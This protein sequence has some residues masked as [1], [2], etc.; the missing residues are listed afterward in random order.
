MIIW[1]ASYPKSGNT[2]V[3]SLL[4]S[5]IF[6]KDGSFS[7]E[8]LKNIKQFPDNSLFKKIG[9]DINNEE[10]MYKNYINS[11]KIFHNKKSIR[12]L[13]THSAFVNKDGFKFTDAKHTLGVI[14][15][16]RDPRNIVSSFSHHFQKN[17]K[18][19]LENLLTPQY[20]GKE[21]VSHCTTW[22]GSWKYHYNSWK[23]FQKYNRYLIVKYEDL[24]LSTE[25]TFINILKFI[26]R[27]NNVKFTINSKKLTKTL[28]TTSFNKMQK[29][30]KEENF[31]EAKINSKTG[32]K[33]KFFNL[34]IKNDWKKFLDLETKKKLEKELE[35]EM[36][37][38]NY[39][40]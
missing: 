7:F 40:D 19:S 17:I 6:S 34:G 10:E 26:A 24:V 32:E 23:T 9:V 27:L 33:I 25:K 16:V 11:Q 30:E 38:L 13:K 8:L 36:K 20:L 18:Q 1:L 21:S 22:M 5:Y 29:L 2:L 28:E 37:E 39:L 3:R 31:V 35:K 4:S 14:Y 12:F 15:I